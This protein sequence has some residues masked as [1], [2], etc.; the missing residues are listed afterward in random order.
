[1]PSTIALEAEGLTTKHNILSLVLSR[2]FT[3]YI[4]AVNHH[5]TAPAP[6]VSLS[7]IANR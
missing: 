4:T 1:M 2:G 3:F 5:K 7:L 6:A